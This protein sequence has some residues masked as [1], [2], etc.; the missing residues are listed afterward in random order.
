VHFDTPE[1]QVQADLIWAATSTDMM[2]LCSVSSPIASASGLHSISASPVATELRNWLLNNDHS[3]ALQALIQQRQ[4][5]RLGIYYEVL[6]QY[7]FEHY[8]GFQLIGQNLPV[9]KNSRT[10]GEM[11]FV[12]YCQQRQRHVHLETAVKFYL[13]LPESGTQH[14]TENASSPWSRWI[15][16]GCKD[17]LDLKLTKMLDKQTRLSTT[18]EGITALEKLGAIQPLRE[19]CLKGYFFYPLNGVCPPSQHSHQQHARG[20]WLKLQDIDLLEEQNAWY[21]MKKEQWLAP[22]SF[23]DAN[24]LFNRQDLKT[25][26]ESRLS[27]NPFPIMIASMQSHDRGYREAARYF[28]TPNTWPTG[29]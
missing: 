5:H 13:G 16:P 11:D 23:N 25:E 18:A 10:L 14:S 1:Q 4:P 26:I 17:R 15:G 9:T 28:I 21:I 27:S 12:Y 20:Y 8:P 19:I 24:T 22:V 6:W 29:L 7:I 3:P 2:Q